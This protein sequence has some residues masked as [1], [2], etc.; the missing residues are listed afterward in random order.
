MANENDPKMERFA[1]EMVA[2]IDA[3]RPIVGYGRDMNVG[4][5]YGYEDGGKTFCWRD[6]FKGDTPVVL[7]VEKTGPWILMLGE[8]RTPPS[9]RDRLI[10]AMKIAVSNWHRPA[11]QPPE[12]YYYLWGREALQA[13]GEDL[14]DAESFTAEQLKAL[15]F[16]NWWCF[17]TLADARANAPAFLTDNAGA[18]TAP[19]RR[20]V[21]HAA[22]I[23]TKEADL[24]AK[25][26]T[27]KDAFHGPW[28]GKKFE[29]WTAAVRK[30]ERDILAQALRLETQAVA[31]MEKALVAEGVKAPGPAGEA[32]TREQAEA[33][34]AEHAGL[35]QGWSDDR[36]RG[37][38]QTLLAVA[39][40]FR[41]TDVAARALM[42]AAETHA[43]ACEGTRPVGKDGW[44]R[45]I[46]LYRRVAD[47]Y[48]GTRHAAEARWRIA[49]CYG[50]WERW[51]CCRFNQGKEDWAKAIELYRALHADAED[52]GSKCDALRRIAEIQ[53]NCLGDWREGLTTYRRMAEE[54]PKS[55][56]KSPYA[57]NRTCGPLNGTHLTDF[58]LMDFTL[59]PLLDAAKTP[60][61]AEALRADFVRLA[62]P[63]ESIKYHSLYQLGRALRRLKNIQ[64]A[65]VVEAELGLCETWLAV[66]PFT[67]PAEAGAAVAPPPE[68]AKVGRVADAWRLF[69]PAVRSQILIA[70]GPEADVAAGPIDPG[71]TYP[72]SPVNGNKA[73]AGWVAPTDVILQKTFKA[74]GAFYALT[75]VNS[76]KAQPAQLRL[77]ASGPAV[78]WLNGRPVLFGDALDYPV[79]D[80]NIA[81]VSLRRG[82]N[83]LLIKF[84][85]WSRSYRQYVRL[86]DPAGRA[87]A[88][89]TYAVPAA[90]VR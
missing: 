33:L 19:A 58:D 83:E 5:A 2:A 24:L 39:E 64:R 20:A 70:F 46:A 77:A 88:G 41:G 30:R 28:A 78:A 1:G 81:P 52:P 65:R 36:R 79:I 35:F 68:L 75:R 7:P 85:P 44:N 72:L 32:M 25:P 26:L 15:H 23:Y 50:C 9:D 87:V 73:R 61:E 43:G 34:L 60:A 17:S 31:E 71:K 45:A 27:E 80:Q 49:G 74:S 51:G 3:G 21:S 84:V 4:V 57:T 38:G 13:W 63:S 54:F 56:A 10:A 47:A 16:A 76:P 14:R 55:P 62:P 11:K 69:S 42:L 18:L 67:G 53:A 89:L 59:S 48:P 12:G 66:G 90:G 6:Y 86:T 22:A 8:H 82:Q 37:M 29:D 40:Q